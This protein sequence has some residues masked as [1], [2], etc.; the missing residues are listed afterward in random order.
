MSEEAIEK[1]RKEIEASGEVDK[2]ID[3]DEEKTI[4]RKGDGLGL[5]STRVES[6]LN[7]MC[8]DGGW[9]REIDIIDDLL[10]LLRET[11]SD[12]GAIDQKEWEHCINYAVAMNMPRKRA[13]QLGVKFVA[14][15]RLKIKKKFLG[16][17]W[18]KP[19]Q[20]HYS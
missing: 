19:L 7:L 18:F 5:S 8:R 14:D 4:Y 16:G 12:D 11:T 6:M 1:L 10:D 3:A 13:M 20:E 2:Y 15:N 9:T 17:D